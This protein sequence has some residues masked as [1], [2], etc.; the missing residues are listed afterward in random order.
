M[1]IINALKEVKQDKNI[2]QLEKKHIQRIYISYKA[3][4]DEVGFSKVVT[5]ETII[6]NKGSLNIA[7]YL[8]NVTIDENKL[9]FNDSFSNW[10][11]NSKTLKASMND[12]FQILE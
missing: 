6:N 11:T 2:G 4:T 12:L 5:I 10:E 1:L 9:S 3:F 7:Q 8:S